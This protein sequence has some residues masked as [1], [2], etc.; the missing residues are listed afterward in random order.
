MAFL[1]WL[2]LLPVLTTRTGAGSR[3]PGWPATGTVIGHITG[4]LYGTGQTFRPLPP[5]SCGGLVIN[6]GV[7]DGDDN[8]STR[9]RRVVHGHHRRAC[10]VERNA[11]G[12]IA[13]SKRSRV[14][15]CPASASAMLRS[16][17]AP[18]VL[19]SPQMCAVVAND[20]KTTS[21]VS[22]RRPPR[23]PRAP[24]GW[25]SPGPR[26]GGPSPLSTTVRSLPCEPVPR[27][28]R[29]RT[30]RPPRQ[31]LRQPHPPHQGTSREVP[32]DRS[33]LRWLV[34]NLSGSHVSRRV[35]SAS[36][37]NSRSYVRTLP[38]ETECKPYRSPRP[39]SLWC[40]SGWRCGALPAGNGFEPLRSRIRSASNSAT[41]ANTN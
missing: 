40:R 2:A 14:V 11:F 34:C 32:Q 33:D 4:R 16:S 18:A 13:R 10:L 31:P 28:R 7:G 5:L 3:Y 24:A 9:R 15:L 20:A 41:I 39:N 8:P 27:H 30:T 6:P 19:S 26:R 22:D 36:A 21:M 1:W 12:E 38:L 29:A 25:P 23:P 17:A 35:V 37:S